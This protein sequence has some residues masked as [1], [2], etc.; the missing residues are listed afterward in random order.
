[1]SG[2]T[3]RSRCRPAAPPGRHTP[4]GCSRTRPSCGHGL[5][6]TPEQCAEAFFDA[7]WTGVTERFI[8]SSSTGPCREFGRGP[9]C[10]ELRRAGTCPRRAE[11]R[12]NVSY[13]LLPAWRPALTSDVG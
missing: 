5:R 2:P 8:T 13:R 4:L 10:G 7:A 12:P 1:M 9:R 3:S 6:H 11:C